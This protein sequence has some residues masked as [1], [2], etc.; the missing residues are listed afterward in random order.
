MFI[1]TTEIAFGSAPMY[2]HL[3]KTPCANFACANGSGSV[4]SS[5][6][7]KNVYVKEFIASNQNKACS[8][9]DVPSPSHERQEFSTRVTGHCNSQK[10]LYK[11]RY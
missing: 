6:Q 8:L 10:S 7:Q 5:E 9:L 1:Q 3:K 4:Y 2:D 11:A